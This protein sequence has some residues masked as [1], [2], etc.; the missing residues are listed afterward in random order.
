[1]TENISEKEMKAIIPVNRFGEPE[2]VAHLV[3]FLVS[4]ESSY[5]TGEVI[6]ING[7]MY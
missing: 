5:I 3:S 1:M 4:P 7:G 6:S 2:E